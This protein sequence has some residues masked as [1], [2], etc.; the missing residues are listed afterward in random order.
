MKK[1]SLHVIIYISSES[2]RV[3]TALSV[4]ICRQSHLLFVTSLDHR[5]RMFLIKTQQNYRTRSSIWEIV[6]IKYNLADLQM[7]ISQIGKPPIIF[8]TTL[9]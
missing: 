6:I 3:S 5:P 2:T 1:T 8:Y 9:V 4:Y 7:L